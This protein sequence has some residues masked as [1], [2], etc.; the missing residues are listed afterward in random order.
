M[1]SGQDGILVKASK[2][3]KEMNRAQVEESIGLAI[4]EWELEKESNKSYNVTLKEYL[5]SREEITKAK[6]DEPLTIVSGDN[7]V[8]IDGNN[9]LATRS[10]SKNLIKNGYLEDKSNNNFSKFNYH[11]DGYLYMISKKITGYYKYM[12]DEYI[13]VDTS[14]KYL[15][16]IM[17]K[18]NN[19][20]GEFWIGLTE[21]DRDYNRISP[22]NIMYIDKTL[23][24]LTQ[25]LK[26]GDTEV[27]L[28]DVSNFMYDTDTKTY[29][30]GLILWNYKDSTGY[31]YP[32]LTYSR[33]V[34]NKLFEYNES[35]PAVDKE[36]NI[37]KLKEPWSNGTVEKNTQVSQS[38]TGADYKYLVFKE[39]SKCEWEKY[40]II[41]QGEDTTGY[42][43]RNKFRPGTKYVKWTYMRGNI[44]EDDTTTY[45]KDI[46]FEE[47]E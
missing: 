9:N 38:N 29:Q 39:I 41:I 22:N 36:N 6:I 37:I 19:I 18:T 34:Y 2:A 3:K 27:Y 46:A 32:P 14:K 42:D 16:S 20:D 12:I 33:N 47:V 31:Q 17:F 11:K 30:M 43:L 4:A 45:I 13:P 10:K 35:E 15:E 1:L 8:T 7:V 44:T 24:Y 40:N 26:D 21:Y 28:N 5:D 23:T 25:D